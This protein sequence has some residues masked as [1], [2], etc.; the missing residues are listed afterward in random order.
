MDTTFIHGVY[1]DLRGEVDPR[2]L[3]PDKVML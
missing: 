3:A 2:Q 1:V